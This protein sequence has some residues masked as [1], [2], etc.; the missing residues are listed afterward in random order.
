MLAHTGMRDSMESLEPI[1][2]LFEQ[3]GNGCELHKPQKVGG[4]IFPTNQEPS[5]PLEPRKEPLREPSTLIAPEMAP[6]LG[7]EFAGGAMRR[8]HVDAVLLEIVIEPVA[9]VGAI[10]DEMFGLGLQH[11]EVETELHQRHF[12]MIRGMRTDRERQPMAIDNREDLHAF[13]TAGFPDVVP[14]AL[15]HG[16]RGIDEA[17]ALVDRAGLAQGIGELRENLAQPFAFAPLLKPAMHRFVV[18]VALRQQMPL[19]AR[20]QNPEHGFQNRARGYRFAAGAAF[21]EVFLGK[22]LPNAFPLIVAQVQHAGAL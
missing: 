17:F 22:M 16:E 8:D 12:M 3:H 7:L 6:V 19:R 14:A 11:V 21:R 4:V 2:K 10:A 9:I 1:S 13:T 15:C 20:V 18:G 5:F